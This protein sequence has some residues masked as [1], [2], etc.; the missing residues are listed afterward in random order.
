[1]QRKVGNQRR[2][3]SVVLRV[4][5]RP[6]AA[7]LSPM[8][9]AT[10]DERGFVERRSGGIVSSEVFGRRVDEGAAG[11]RT[12]PVS[13]MWAGPSDSRSPGRVAVAIMRGKAPTFC[14]ADISPMAV[15]RGSLWRSRGRNHVYTHTSAHAHKYTHTHTRTRTHTHTHARTHTHTHRHAHTHAPP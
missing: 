10:S 7:H 3:K 14:E 6:Y 4:W 1:M 12:P 8:P 9:T 5:R 13:S 2:D 15:V 11:F